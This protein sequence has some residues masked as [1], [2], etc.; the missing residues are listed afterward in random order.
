MEFPPVRD[1]LSMDNQRST[2]EIYDNE[3]FDEM[4][5]QGGDSSGSEENLMDLGGTEKDTAT[6][7]DFD[8]LKVIG[9]GSFGKVY[10]VEGV[11]NGYLHR[12]LGLYEIFVEVKRLPVFSLYHILLAQI[13]CQVVFQGTCEIVNQLSSLSDTEHAQSTVYAFWILD[14]S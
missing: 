9:K 11:T 5:D 4:G 12:L 8:L 7:T 14:C 13:H 3:T 6:I 2:F 1:F 10:G